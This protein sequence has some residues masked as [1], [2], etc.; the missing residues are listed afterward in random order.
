MRGFRTLAKRIADAGE[1][2]SVI[3]NGSPGPV[4]S[5]GCSE[6]R[7]IRLSPGIVGSKN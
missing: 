7:V 2:V 4:Q 6:G 3:A 1:M 5:R